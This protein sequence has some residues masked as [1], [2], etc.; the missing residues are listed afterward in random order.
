MPIPDLLRAPLIALLQALIQYLEQNPEPLLPT[1]TPSTTTQNDT[2]R[3]DPSPLCPQNPY[4]IIPH[5]KY[6]AR[7]SKPC[8]NCPIQHCEYHATR[9]CHN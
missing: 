8:P 2:P 4:F 3:W 1:H 6:C 5:C 7:D 9:H